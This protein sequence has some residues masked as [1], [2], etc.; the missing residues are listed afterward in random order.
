MDGKRASVE[1]CLKIME[2]RSKL[3]GLGARYP[4]DWIELVKEARGPAASVRFAADVRHVAVRVLDRHD[5]R[6]RRDRVRRLR[7]A[8]HRLA[9]KRLARYLRHERW[10]RHFGF[11]LA[12]LEDALFDRV[13]HVRCV[14]VRFRRRFLF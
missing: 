4:L 5:E 2:R 12:L 9:F 6:R 13:R 14:E 8:R 3:L 7:R 11:Q 10:A 1:C